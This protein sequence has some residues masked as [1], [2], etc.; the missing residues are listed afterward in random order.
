M[1]ARNTISPEQE[2]SEFVA[3][4]SY[5]ATP[6][7][8][9]GVVKNILLT[10]LG[11][12]IAGAAEDGCA[13]LRE[14]S[15]SQG[16]KPE[17][18][19]LVYGDRLPAAQ[20]ALLN[21]VMAR[22][23]DYCDAMAPGLHIGS[24]LVPAALAAAELRGGCD[25]REFIAALAAGAELAS[26][27]NL[28]ESMYD[29]F[30][31]T[32]VAGV[33]AS[34]AAVCR[35]LHASAHETHHAL[36]LAFN[37]AGGSFQSNV[38]GSLAVRLIQGWV[39]ETGVTCARLAKAGLTGPERFFSGVYGYRH[40]FGRD[41]LTAE[42]VSGSL[43]IRW[44]LH[45]AVFKKYPSCGLTQAVTELTLG[46]LREFPFEPEQLANFEI[47]LPPYAYRLVGHEFRLGDN[48]RVDAQFSAQYCVANAIV[49]RSSTLSYFRPDAIAEPD[50]IA[51]IPCIRC[52]ADKGLDTRGHTAVDIHIELKDG[53]RRSFS[54]DHPLGFPE[55]PLSQADHRQR[56][57]D[58]VSYADGRI[59]ADQAKRLVQMIDRVETQ[60]DVRQLIALT[61]SG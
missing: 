6:A 40:L 30:D 53:R 52:V 58:C 36:A 43:G 12:T 54:L 28:T 7:D 46:A 34:T 37:R 35:L 13:A 11:T 27:L 17:A 41:Q 16:G 25:G 38:D 42:S 20:A 18:T 10:V 45:A 33:F 4:A 14:L 8:A 5:E 49:R 57:S 39:A 47:V 29:G 61:M 50:V 55:R 3:G 19:V 1:D 59:G 24:S 22:A 32:G 2:L 31:P 60:A 48:P 26:R 56:F 9:I 21:G 44:A 15:L 23:L 51:L